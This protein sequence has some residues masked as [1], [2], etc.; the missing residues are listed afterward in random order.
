MPL[1]LAFTDFPA[2]L[3]VL[4]RVAAIL[5]TMPLLGERMVPRQVKVAMAL[6]LALL[7]F[8]AVAGTITPR[9]PDNPLAWVPALVLEV[10]VGGVIG[11]TV[12]LITS[13]FEF[14]GEVMGFVLGLSL[15]QAVDPQT[16]LQVPII[17]QFLTVLSFL[18]FLSI[19][20]HHV[21]IGALVTSFEWVPPF[22][23]S[24]TA[25]FADLVV[26][27]A[28][29]LFRLGL[30]IAAPVIAAILLANVGLGIVA[31]AVPQMHVM[32][33]AMPMTIAVGFLVLGLSLPY[34]AGAMATAYGGLGDTLAD[35]M[36]TLR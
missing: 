25:G 24:V 13:A 31:R 26:D 6:L 19:N 35:L 17:G 11:F 23:M 8:P 5:G 20:A 27:L 3:L 33:V 36:A 22:G 16:R 28:F 14:A 2:F 10:L 32:L 21:L 34:M 29:Q 12:R 30:Q 18:T 7:L 1:P 15:A 4:V 9:V